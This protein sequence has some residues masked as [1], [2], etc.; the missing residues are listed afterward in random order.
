MEFV[1]RQL[2]IFDKLMALTILRHMSFTNPANHDTAAKT[3]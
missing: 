3:A 2:I 1:S